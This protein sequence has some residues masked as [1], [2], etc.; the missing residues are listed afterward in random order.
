[1][2][3]NILMISSDRK[4]FDE[5]DKYFENQ[6]V[7]TC[8]ICNI[9]EAIYKIQLNECCLIILD[10]ASL[11][12]CG[13]EIIITMRKYS[14]APILVLLGNGNNL[15]KITALKNGADNV[16]EKPFAFEVLLAQI[17]ALLRRYTE[18]NH[19]T[20]KNG[21]IICYGTLLLDMGRREVSIDG[22]E[23]IL[24][25]KEYEIL[26]Y[27]LKNRWRTLTSEQ[28]YEAVWKEAYLD[29]KSIIFYHIGQ[30]RRLMGEGWIETV[31]GVD[32]RLCNKAENQRKTSDRP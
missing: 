16:L 12:Y 32:Y 9:K 1:M 6:V 11:K 24:P 10:L 7:D 22:Q 28:I 13:D 31:Y 4:L 26:L 5:I 20:Y 17:E 21:E 29:D 15:N 2:E 18:F 14:P 19:I 30:L 23:I 8:Y 25:Y 3:K 27:M